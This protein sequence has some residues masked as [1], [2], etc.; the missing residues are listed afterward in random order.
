MDGSIEW[1]TLRD[2]AGVERWIIEETATGFVAHLAA[3]KNSWGLWLSPT[4]PQTCLVAWEMDEEKEAC[5]WLLEESLQDS[6]GWSKCR[7]CG[8]VIHGGKGPSADYCSSACQDRA[9]H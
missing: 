9:E 4:L 7:N 5:D 6:L 1:K 8:K 2:V 3:K